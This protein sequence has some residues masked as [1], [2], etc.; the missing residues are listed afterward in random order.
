MEVCYV[1]EGE[2]M[3]VFTEAQVPCDGLAA[4]TY[5]GEELCDVHP[6]RGNGMNVMW[7]YVRIDSGP[8]AGQ[9]VSLRTVMPASSAAM[10]ETIDPH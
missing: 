6:L 1:K 4:G 2:Y 9:V 7:R 8:L 3:V 5:Q 10:A